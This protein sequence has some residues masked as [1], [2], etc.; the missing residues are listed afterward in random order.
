[1]ML[2]LDIK[3]EQEAL[4]ADRNFTCRFPC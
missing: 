1:L 2:E 3:L 4:L